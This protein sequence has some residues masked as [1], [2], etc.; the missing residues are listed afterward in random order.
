MMQFRLREARDDMS[1]KAVRLIVL[2]DDETPEINVSFFSLV[3]A[4]GLFCEIVRLHI[5]W[6]L[7]V[8]LDSEI[9][10]HAYYLASWGN[11]I[12]W[13]PAVVGETDRRR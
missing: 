12:R 4:G 5:L 1:G 2:D 6:R 8:T 3:K 11:L 9:N 10:I 7:P 13:K